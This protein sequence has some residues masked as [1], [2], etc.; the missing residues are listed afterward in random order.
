MIEVK[1]LSKYYDKR[2]GAFMQKKQRI[3]ALA[4]VSFCARDGEISAL[5]GANGAGKSSALRIIATLLK[6]DSGTV[7][8]DGFDS[9][10]EALQVRKHLGFM[11]HNSGLYPRLTAVEN[12]RYYAE[13]AG[14][15]GDKLEKSLAT[16][17]PMLDMQEIAERRCG[18]FSQGQTMKVA[19]ARALIHKPK[20]LMLDEPSNGLDVMATRKL[21]TILRRL[22][23]EG[24]CIL[25][26]SHIMQEVDAL[27][28]HVAIINEGRITLEGAVADIK[29]QTGQSNLED[30]FVFAIGESLDE[31]AEAQA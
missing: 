30:A 31:N 8:V 7:S 11:P 29:R 26:S 18:G 3:C 13:I 9:A 22:R 6:A 5:L 17:I 20:T 4:D 23:D 10:S 27:C 2:G 28:D 19:L 14:V 12:I 16:L 15:T 24:H 25:L 21:R 1:G